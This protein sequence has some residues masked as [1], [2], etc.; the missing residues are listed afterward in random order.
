MKKILL[1]SFALVVS[2]FTIAQG[3]IISEYVEGSHTNK[4][5]ELYN[6]TSSPI[7]LQADGYQIVRYSNGSNQ[8]LAS[9]TL[10]LI[11]T[12]PAHGCFV[13][14]LDK[15]DPSATGQ[16]TML[17]QGLIA[18]AD[19]FA[20]PVYNVNN[21]M[22]FNGNDA[23]SLEL[24]TNV[25]IDLIGEIGVNPG[26]SW[27]MDITA[28]YT[29]ALGGRWWT[30][31]HTLIR[32]ETITSGVTSNPTPFIV[33]TEWDSLSINTFDYLGTHPHPVSMDNAVRVNKAY[34]FPNPSASGE[35]YIKATAIITSVELFNLIGQTNG[36]IMNPSKLG[37]MT[38]NTENYKSGIY[39]M[40]IIFD[41]NTTITKKI[42]IK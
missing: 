20:C 28:G 19:T 25:I 22:Y 7:N 31:N 30:K 32:K 5:L 40:K 1:L 34:I 33:A 37:D 17:F 9:K 38:I 15:R 3:L 11:G 12:V 35:I 8:K 21:A 24:S 41:D 27:T 36:L 26:D 23:V 4:A 42:I 18:K 6:T 13:I 14:A 29:S 10:D 2:V 39:A 16:D